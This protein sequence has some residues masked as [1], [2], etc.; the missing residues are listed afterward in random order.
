M[1]NSPHIIKVYDF[2]THAGETF[3]AMEYLEGESL[4]DHILRQSTLTVRQT[5]DFATQI[6]EALTEIHRHDVVHRDIKPENILVLRVKNRTFIKLLD[7]GIAKRIDPN[8]QKSST[9]VGTPSYM[10]PEQVRGEPVDARADI[11]SLG[12]LMYACLVGEPPF[13]YESLQELH[14]VSLPIPDIGEARPGLSRTL[15]DIVNAMMHPDRT[16]RPTTAAEVLEKLRALEGV[17]EQEEPRTTRPTVKPAGPGEATMPRARPRAVEETGPSI[18]L[19]TIPKGHASPDTPAP[20]KFTR[21]R[22]TS[23]GGSRGRVIAA[24]ILLLAFLAALDYLYITTI[25][26]RSLDQVLDD[27]RTHQPVARPVP[28]TDVSTDPSAETDA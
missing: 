25:R 14:S 8:S 13:H 5:L 15:R 22:T 3:M 1:F 19:K 9:Q 2:G 17:A 24:I 21:P 23:R 26:G 27:L 11:Y 12:I 7:F 28:V 10:P 20:M 4:E 18:P 16:Q 6:A